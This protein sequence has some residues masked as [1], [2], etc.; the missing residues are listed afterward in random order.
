MFKKIVVGIDGSDH[1]ETALKLA[2]DLAG[3]YGAE[4]HL[5]HAPQPE[6][7]AFALGAMPGYAVLDTLPSPEDVE[8][9]ANQ[10]MD[11]AGSV[12]G[13]CGQ[14][15]A[16]TFV[17]QGEPADIIVKYANEIGADLIVSGRRGLGAVGALLQGS[18]TQRIGKLAECAVLSVV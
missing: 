8:K 10:L 5:V 14:T 17:R 2:C 9:A 11:R 4:L 1:S 16:A 12:A 18:T 15:P 13:E 3:K 7:V 6:T